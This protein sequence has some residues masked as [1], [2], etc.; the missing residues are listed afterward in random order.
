[1]MNESPD[2]E[3][4]DDDDHDQ[5]KATKRGIEEHRRWM[6]FT[7]SAIYTFLYVGSF[8]GWG[9]MQLLLEENGSYS[10]KCD[11]AFTSEDSSTTAASTAST[12][13][14]N[15]LVCP[16]QTF[17]LLRIN[18]IATVTQVLS[19]ALGQFVDIYGAKRGYFL[20]TASLWIGLILLTI[21]STRSPSLSADDMSSISV[22]TLDRL[23]YVAFCFMAMA[24]WMGGLLR[25]IQVFSLPDM[26]DHE[27][28]LFSIPYL[29][30]VPLPISSFGGSRIVQQYY[31]KMLILQY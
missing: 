13:S 15:D 19:P 10:W 9:P 26:L 28:F 21:A 3:E 25:Y 11:S 31:S 12:S 30:L 4:N 7:F 1:M 14:T 6:L 20:F 23:L 16:E 5:R 27:L 24:T 22:V 8:Y 2:E 18:L 29:M 17:A